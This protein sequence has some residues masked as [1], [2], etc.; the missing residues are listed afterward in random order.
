MA[1]NPYQPPATTSALEAQSLIWDIGD[2]GPIRFAGKPTDEDL[3]HYLT[4]HDS[5]GCVGIGLC[6]WVFLFVLAWLVFSGI[7]G[8]TAIVVG[9]A[10]IVAITGLVSTKFYRRMTFISMNPNWQ[11]EVSGEMRADGV[12]IDREHCQVFLRW[13]CLDDVVAGDSFVGLLMMPHVSES[14]IIGEEM[15]QR[16]VNEQHVNRFVREIRQQL[17]SRGGVDTRRHF[18]DAL[19]REPQRARSLEVPSDAIAFSGPVFRKELAAARTTSIDEDTESKKT[20]GRS[21]V[22]RPIIVIASLVLGLAL[23]L[24]GILHAILPHDPLL[25]HMLTYSLLAIGWFTYRLKAKQQDPGTVIQFL[26]A[27]ADH[28][29]VTSDGHAIT[30][31]LPWSHIRLLSHEPERIVLRHSQSRRIM[32]IRH[33]MFSD[34]SHWDGFVNLVADSRG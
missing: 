32:V 9:I 31:H 14:L 16:P 6:V 27:Y 20:G 25:A 21:R 13:D 3:D 33:D 17:I 15:L 19:L 22:S 8:A 30:T 5:V 1:I 23:I 29:G 10:L 24:G 28:K 11:G 26:H 2:E 7:A 34:E 18:L 4:V 12:W